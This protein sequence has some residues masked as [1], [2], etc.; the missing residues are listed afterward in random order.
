ME[1]RTEGRESLGTKDYALGTTK[2][3]SGVRIQNAD[4][5]FQVSRNI[6]SSQLKALS[7][8]ERQKAISDW[9]FGN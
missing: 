9:G 7:S 1:Q 6:R 4:V 3:E 2:K 8:K 5:R